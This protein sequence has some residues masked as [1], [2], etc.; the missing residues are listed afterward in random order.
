MPSTLKTVLAIGGTGAQGMSVIK[1]LISDSDYTVRILTRSA[2][3]PAAREAASLPNVSLIEGNTFDDATLRSALQGIDLA[4]VNTNGFAIGEKNEVYWGIRIFEL[5]CEAGVKHFLYAGLDYALKEGNFDPS[6]RCGH[7]DGKGKVIDWMKSQPISPMAWSVLVSGPYMDTLSELMRPHPDLKDPKTLVFAA[8]LGQG[9]VPLIVLSDLGL[10]G[11]WIFDT[12]SRSNGLILKTSTEHVS[13]E[14]LVATFTAITGRKAVYKDVT[15]DEYFASGVF[16]DPERK[17]GHS[18]EQDGTL[19][20]Y[21]ENFS[22]FWNM[23]KASREN[24]GV[25]KRDYAL[26]DEILPGRI[27]TVGEWMKKAGY[28]GERGSILKDWSDRDAKAAAA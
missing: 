14:Y 20:T 25:I 5:C 28:T 13:W 24:K 3:S 21:R 19:Q 23:W 8:P 2:Y 27:R 18:V 16:P 4:F 12:P 15:L 6:F 9:A 1:A 26:L 17:V 7:F 22:G 10:Y 11:K